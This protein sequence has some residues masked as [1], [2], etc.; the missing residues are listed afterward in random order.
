MVTANELPNNST[1]EARSPDY[2]PE[3]SYDVEDP[4]RPRI[5]RARRQA[6][7]AAM[8][9]YDGLMRIFWPSDIA[10]SDFPGVIVGWKNSE[11]D[12]FVVA[13]LEVSDVSGPSSG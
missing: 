5:A 6:A 11:L 2:P 10:R 13:I 4:S 7:L 1:L 3:N 9:V 12:F 8:T